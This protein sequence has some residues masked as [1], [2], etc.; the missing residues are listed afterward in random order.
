MIWPWVV[1]LTEIDLRRSAS[2][3]GLLFSGCGLFR[4]AY[5][6]SRGKFPPRNPLTSPY[7]SQSSEYIQRG[8]MELSKDEQADN[9]ACCLWLVVDGKVA[10]LTTEPNYCTKRTVVV[11]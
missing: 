6:V 7:T 5:Q 11:R 1:R 10:R 2:V 8:R 9:V 3:A 4:V